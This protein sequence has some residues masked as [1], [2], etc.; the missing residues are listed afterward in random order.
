V[1][2]ST[3]REM[4]L[5]EWVDRLPE[6]HH[7]RAVLGH[8]LADSQEL[9]AL[10]AENARMQRALEP[11]NLAAIIRRVDGSHNLGA[12]ELAEAIAAGVAALFTP[13]PAGAFVTLEDLKGLKHVLS[14]CVIAPSLLPGPQYLPSAMTA[15][16]VSR[17]R[18]AAAIRDAEVKT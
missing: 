2:I 7:A 17:N 4:T 16:T 8:L 13:A 5:E 15:L 3:E 18:V 6:A 11:D 14:L 10:R 1:T 12:G 9:A